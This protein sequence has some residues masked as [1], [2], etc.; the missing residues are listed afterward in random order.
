MKHP[1]DVV[2]GWERAWNS[3]DAEAL[4]KLFAEDAEF[5]NVVGLWWH[6]RER[7][8]QAH[9][10]GFTEIFPGSTITMGTPRVRLIGDQ[11]ATVHCR[12]HLVGQISPEG[13]PAQARN[14]IFTFVLECQD[15]GWIVVAAQNTDIVPGTQTHLNT[16]DSQDAIFYRP[17]E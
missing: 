7:I 17:V 4:A 15:N 16:A 11:A 13:E 14:G 6:D 1:K 12:W 9:A 2:R 5:I 3:A 10:F 8:K